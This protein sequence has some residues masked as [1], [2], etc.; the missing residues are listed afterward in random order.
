LVLPVLG[1]LEE[2]VEPMVS[3]ETLVGRSISTL[4]RV[5][6]WRGMGMAKEN[7]HRAFL[8]RILYEGLI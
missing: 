8:S 4:I 3:G 2:A 5:I 7:D 1:L 6:E